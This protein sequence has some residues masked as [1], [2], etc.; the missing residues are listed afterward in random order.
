MWSR[1]IFD[2]ISA[3]RLDCNILINFLFW[4]DEKLPE[5]GERFATPLAL[6]EESGREEGR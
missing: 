3:R 5:F 6:A 1:E 2:K 4:W